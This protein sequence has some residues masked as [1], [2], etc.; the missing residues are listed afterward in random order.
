MKGKLTQNAYAQILLFIITFGFLWI[1]LNDNPNIF[2]LTA[3]LSVLLTGPRLFASKIITNT[4]YLYLNSFRES[5]YIYI[6]TL[7]IISISMSLFI[8]SPANLKFWFIVFIVSLILSV[9][10]IIVPERQFAFWIPVGTAIV[11]SIYLKADEALLLQT[12]HAVILALAVVVLSYYLKF[13]TISGSLMTFLLAITIFGLGGV[14]WAIPILAFF[15][16]SSLLSKAGKGIKER[17]KD[18]FE[19]TGVRDQT[20][21]LANGGIAG[22]IIIIHYFSPS[23]L[24]YY[25]YLISVAVATADT[26]ATEI[27]VLF[28]GKTRLITNFKAASPGVSGAIS[29]EGTA[30]SLIGSLIIISSGMLFIKLNSTMLFFSLVLFGFVG[31]MVDSILGATI[32]SQYHCRVCGKYTEKKIHCNVETKLVSGFKIINN[33]IVNIS[34]TAISVT[35]YFL[36]NLIIAL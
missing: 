18:T 35:I 32:Q 26:W 31:S 22:I 34:S 9:V 29:L 8:S 33:D 12:I 30:G 15:I 3:F 4:E 10:F 20:Q 28:N 23:E 7:S 16:L 13:L 19:K 25:L 27:G 6:T 2:R 21:V 24:F 14:K 17:F 5:V 11:L 36:I 1:L